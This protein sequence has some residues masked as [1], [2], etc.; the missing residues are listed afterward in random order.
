MDKNFAAM[1]APLSAKMVDRDEN[2]NGMLAKVTKM[3]GILVN[4]AAIIKR[5]DCQIHTLVTQLR[6]N[7]EYLTL[8]S[9]IAQ[10]F[11]HILKIIYTYFSLLLL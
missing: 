3:D 4:Q 6:W 5:Q 11:I 2:Y 1:T 8:D 10:L 9:S 7:N